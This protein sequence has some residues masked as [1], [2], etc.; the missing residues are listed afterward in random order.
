M[1]NRCR[2]GKVIFASC[3]SATVAAAGLTAKYRDKRHPMRVYMCHF[4]H[5]HTTRTKTLHE[6]RQKFGLNNEAR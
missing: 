1:N 4:L 6:I 3:E 5:W 2:C